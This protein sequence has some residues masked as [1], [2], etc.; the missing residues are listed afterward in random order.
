M[1]IYKPLAL[2]LSDISVTLQFELSSING[3]RG[4]GAQMFLCKPSIHQILQSTANQQPTNLGKPPFNGK[5]QMCL[6]Q[7]HRAANP[8]SSNPEKRG[9]DGREKIRNRCSEPQQAITLDPKW[10]RCE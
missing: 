5:V 7:M 2:E 9:V 4:V 8:S 1:D 3:R 6:F 10:Q